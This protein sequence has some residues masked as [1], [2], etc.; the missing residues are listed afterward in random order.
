MHKQASGTDPG[1]GGYMIHRY[2][3]IVME[4]HRHTYMVILS[5]VDNAFVS[6]EHLKHIAISIHILIVSACSYDT[7]FIL[8]EFTTLREFQ[9]KFTFTGTSEHTSIR[10]YNKSLKYCSS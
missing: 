1:W 4:P 3:G 2:L 7:E 6:L 10:M 5:Y 8:A 9:Y